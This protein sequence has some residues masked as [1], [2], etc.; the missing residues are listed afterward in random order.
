MMEHMDWHSAPENQFRTGNYGERFLLFHKQYIDKFDVFRHS[1]GF[2]A[3]VGWDP[4]TIIPP[5]LP[6]DVI[7]TAPRATNDPYSVNHACKTPTW[8]TLAGGTDID[9]LHGYT[10]LCQFQSLDELGRSIDSG[11]HGAVHNTIG[12]DMSQFH[13]PVDPIFWPWHKWVDNVRAT[14]QQCNNIFGGIHVPASFVQIL[15]GIIND[16]G[17][18]ERLPSGQIIHVPPR[19]PEELT[20]ISEEKLHGLIGLAL[21][22]ISSRVTHVESRQALQK[23][24]SNLTNMASK[25]NVRQTTGTKVR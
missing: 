4:S 14:W 8:L 15:F 3:V 18:I 19:G 16:G 2:M 25:K 23:V 9:P 1:K 21:D 10:S 22:T 24:A 13:S 20:R 6:H 17:G 7:L 12:G 11:W 5:N